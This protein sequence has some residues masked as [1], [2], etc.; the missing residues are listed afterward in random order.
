MLIPIIHGQRRMGIELVMLLLS[1]RLR[2]LL[3]PLLLLMLLLRL[4][5]IGHTHR[6]LS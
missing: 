1:L 6:P 2:L 5:I 3:R 4:G